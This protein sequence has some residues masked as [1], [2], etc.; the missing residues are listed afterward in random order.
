ME[1]GKG[2][3]AVAE[4][5]KTSEDSRMTKKALLQLPRTVGQH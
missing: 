4:Q 2:A 3:E 5:Q 1:A